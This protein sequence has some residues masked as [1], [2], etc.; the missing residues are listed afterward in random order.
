MATD[1]HSSLATKLIL[2]MQQSS[3]KTTFETIS[4]SKK[5]NTPSRERKFTETKIEKGKQDTPVEKKLEI[6]QTR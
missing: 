6:E 1:K 4:T 5:Q 2:K 3:N